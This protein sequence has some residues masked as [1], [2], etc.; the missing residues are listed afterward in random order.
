MENIVII[1]T[2]AAGDV[3]RTTV[4]LHLFK[5]KNITWITAGHNC[6]VLPQ[7][8]PGLKILDIEMVNPSSLVSDQTISL[9]DDIRCAELASSIETKKITGTYSLRGD[10][11]YTDDSSEWFDMGLISKLGKKIA[12][13][14]KRKN[15]KSYQEILFNMFRK[16]FQGEEYVS[17]E[18]IVP[19]G[20]TEI[21]L[22]ARAGRRWPTKVWNK[23]PQLADSLVKRGFKIKWLQQKPDLKKYM[24]EIAACS[25]IITGDTLAM[26]VALAYK[27][28]AVALF[29]CTSPSEIYPYSHLVKVVSP[30][31]DEAFYSTIY[32]PEAVEAITLDMVM[33]ALNSIQQKPIQ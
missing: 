23:Y 2:G 16:I 19:G 1:K 25:I 27:I 26:H 24:E 33:D 3:L 21:G 18:D 22:E 5:G 15:T 32:H 11:M 30:R 17:R 6:E 12:D 4:L 9:D 7:V 28:P 10:V 29:T 31:I 13:D 14:L 8:F 20:N